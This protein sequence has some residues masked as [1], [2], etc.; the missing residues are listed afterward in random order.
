MAKTAPDEAWQTTLLSQDETLRMPE[1]GIEIP[2]DKIYEG[3]TVP[4]Q[5]AAPA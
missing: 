3:I 1:I 2:V 4:D 5:D